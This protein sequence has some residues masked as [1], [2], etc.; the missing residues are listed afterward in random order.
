L[1]KTDQPAI[2]INFFVALFD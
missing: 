2:V 1:L